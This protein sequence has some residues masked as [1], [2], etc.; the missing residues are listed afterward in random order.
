MGRST[1]PFGNDGKMAVADGL[2]ARR[3]MQLVPNR[4]AQGKAAGRE[5]L[6]GTLHERVELLMS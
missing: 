5:R 4:G 2:I 1:K 6:K 3:P